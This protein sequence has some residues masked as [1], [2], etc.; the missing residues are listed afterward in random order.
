MAKMRGVEPFEVLWE[1]R[2]TLSLPEGVLCELI[3]ISDLVQAKKTQR[4]K[5]WPMIRR[6]V[7]AHHE[8]FRDQPSPAQITF[9]VA[10]MRSPELLVFVAR[11]YGDAA[12]ELAAGRR[13]LAIALTAD[14]LATEEA[15]AAEEREERL[16]DRDYW[17]PL[18]KELEAMRHARRGWGIYPGERSSG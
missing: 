4:D 14:V 1:R 8:Q 12:R 11:K 5:D 15:L 7:E 16:R 3:S 6:S 9:W 2:T 18:K 17:V 13:A 10:E